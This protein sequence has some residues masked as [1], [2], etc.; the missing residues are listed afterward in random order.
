[1]ARYEYLIGGSLGERLIIGL[2]VGV[3]AYL[4]LTDPGKAMRSLRG[5]IEMFIRLFT[6]ILAALLLASALGAL[7][8]EEL[9]VRHLGEESGPGRVVA[10]GLLGGMLLGGPFATYPIMERVYEQGAGYPSLLAMYVGYGL[11]SVGRVP[12]GLVI[13]SPSIVG[14]RLAFAVSVTVLASLG[15]YLVSAVRSS[16]DGVSS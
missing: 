7:L 12:Y 1:M 14:L 11:I 2:T 16:S 9:V 13:F 6:L 5:G 10:A 8:P 3:Y 4:L 15:I